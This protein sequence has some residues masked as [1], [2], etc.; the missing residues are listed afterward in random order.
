MCRCESVY[1]RHNRLK[2]LI[3]QRRQRLCKRTRFTSKRAKLHPKTHSTFTVMFQN[4]KSHENF[5]AEVAYNGDNQNKHEAMDMKAKVTPQ[6]TGLGPRVSGLGQNRCGIPSPLWSRIW[7]TSCPE[8]GPPSCSSATA[9][10]QP[11]KRTKDSVSHLIEY[12][13]VLASYTNS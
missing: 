4:Y 6:A 5:V 9:S 10:R 3:G 11:G 12:A 7:R 1:K 2:V 13:F 8:R